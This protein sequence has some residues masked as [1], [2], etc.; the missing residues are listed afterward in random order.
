MSL[1]SFSLRVYTI[2]LYIFNLAIVILTKI[3]NL[4]ILLRLNLLISTN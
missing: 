4:C 1:F 3:I 2:Y